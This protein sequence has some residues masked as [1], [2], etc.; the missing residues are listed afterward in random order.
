MSLL[1]KLKAETLSLKNPQKAKILSNFFKTGKGEYGEGDIFYGINVPQSR[2][3]AVKY[4][5]LPLSQVKK[6]LQS[7]IHEERLISLLILVHNHNKNKDKR[8]E[9]IKFYLANTNKINSWDLVDLTADKILGSHLLNKDKSLLYKLAR[10]SNLWEKRI[11]IISTF[12]FIK[13]NQFGETLSISKLLLK[14]K[15][16]LI[17][18]AV[19]WML[20]EIGKRSL[21][22]LEGFLKDNY[23]E[24][25]RTTLSYAI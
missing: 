17:Q 3:I 20:R 15:H 2:K 12:Y 16:D 21:S 13:N 18:K 14:D 1:I 6:L 8:N 22:T 19:G 11:S 9:I 4:S 5:S 23:K 10:S 24:M 7:K 25:S